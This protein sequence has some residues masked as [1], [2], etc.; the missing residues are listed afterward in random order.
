MC[1]NF[2]PWTIESRGDV[3][4]MEQL[5]SEDPLRDAAA[6]NEYG[7]GLD[8]ILKPFM[9]DENLI[10]GTG[11]DSLRTVAQ[12]YTTPVSEQM[13]LETGGVKRMSRDA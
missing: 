1:R 9:S 12:P 11:K 7:G 2:Q 5:P 6:E 13:Y 8:G 4:V 10:I 3:N